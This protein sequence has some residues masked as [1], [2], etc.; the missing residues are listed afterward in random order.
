MKIVKLSSTGSTHYT[1]QVSSSFAQRYIRCAMKVGNGHCQQQF[2]TYRGDDLNVS[3]QFRENINNLIAGSILLRNDSVVCDATCANCG[4]KCGRF[5]S[6]GQGGEVIFNDFRITVDVPVESLIIRE[7]G[8]PRE[9]AE[10]TRYHKMTRYVSVAPE[11]LDNIRCFEA[12]MKENVFSL[13]PDDILIENV[14]PCA[15]NQTPYEKLVEKSNNLAKR[16]IVD[17]AVQV[18]NV[19]RAEAP[20]KT[21]VRNVVASTSTTNQDPVAS[22][23]QHFQ[24]AVTSTSENISKHC[25]TDK[26]ATAGKPPK[27]SAPVESDHSKD[28]IL[29][30]DADEPVKYLTRSRVSQ[31]FPRKNYKNMDRRCS[32]KRDSTS[33]KAATKAS[34]NVKFETPHSSNS[35]QSAVDDLNLIVTV[36]SKDKIVSVEKQFHPEQSAQNKITDVK[37]PVTIISEITLAGPSKVE[38]V[39]VQSTAGQIAIPICS[40]PSDTHIAQDNYVA[41]IPSVYLPNMGS[42]TTATYVR[43]NENTVYPTGCM[44]PY[45]VNQT[46]SRADSGSHFENPITVVDGWSNTNIVHHGYQHAHG[47]STRF[48]HHYYDGNNQVVGQGNRYDSSPSIHE[49]SYGAYQG[50]DGSTMLPN[51]HGANVYHVDNRYYV[52]PNVGASPYY[53]WYPATTINY[54]PG[55]VYGST[56]ASSP[57]VNAGTA[58]HELSVV[59][60][61][62]RVMD[63]NDPTVGTSETVDDCRTN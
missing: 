57:N 31:K 43:P 22:T 32:L 36:D 45:Y 3:T 59:D 20:T 38:T 17:D 47:G 5:E 13:E 25:R 14:S 53:N 52:P 42:D 40:V 55:T 23:S 44:T 30:P 4:H 61:F 7:S 2:M 8:V 35:G 60:E 16:G 27:M 58:A 62:V 56:V 24:G 21:S 54:A 37:P 33:G 6:Q 34:K 49:G 1:V 46:T 48:G 11:D 26:R 12:S 10:I 29:T 9:G 39:C 28:A 51:T 50:N 63:T 19:Q 41:P 15:P 18:G